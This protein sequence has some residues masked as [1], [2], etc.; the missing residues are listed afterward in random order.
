MHPAEDRIR[1]NPERLV[2]LLA[3]AGGSAGDWRPEEFRE[4][5]RHQLVAPIWLD[6]PRFAQ[7]PADRTA[8]AS[9][10]DPAGEGIRSF[11]D[12]FH[13][14][15]PPIRLL[16]L[17]KD[18]AKSNWNHP[19]STLPGEIA[20]LLYYESILAAWLHAKVHISQLSDEDLRAGSEWV[21]QQ[22]W[23]DDRTRELFLEGL[24]S[25]GG[26]TGPAA[27]TGSGG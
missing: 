1:A 25:L 3:V 6:V 17:T 5:L 4:I 7:F 16:R 15:A 18:F 19:G 24:V 14:P 10:A 2:R 9:V 21:L 8:G 13:H 23:V 27:S 11:D 22:T 12:L 20:A 26:S